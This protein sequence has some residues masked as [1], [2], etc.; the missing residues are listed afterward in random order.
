MPK[1]GDTQPVVLRVQFYTVQG[2]SEF[3]EFTTA[4]W[5]F[6]VE[7]ERDFF[8]LRECKSYA[9][10][11]PVST[12]RAYE[13]IILKNDVKIFRTVFKSVFLLSKH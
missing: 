13:N 6:D 8:T 10:L 12:S 7:V 3:S 2:G 5:I 9:R 4:K 1:E 11:S